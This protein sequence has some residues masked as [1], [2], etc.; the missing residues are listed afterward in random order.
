MVYYCT[1][2]QARKKYI[3]MRINR[4]GQYFR[5]PFTESKNDG[6][7]GGEEENRVV[8]TRERHVLSHT[9]LAIRWVNRQS[10]LT[11][12]K[13]DETQVQDD[14]RR[15]LIIYFMLIVLKKS[16]TKNNPARYMRVGG[17]HRDF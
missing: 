8:G 3:I 17:T 13:C 7:A 6:G 11:D 10:G 9:S 1:A 14:R 4:V 5:K 12:G 2:T 15:L 16:Q